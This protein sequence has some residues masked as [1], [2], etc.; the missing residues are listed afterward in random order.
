MALGPS[1][2]LR[3]GLGSTSR[4]DGGGVHV[5]VT[6]RTGPHLA[7]ALFEAAGLDRFAALVLITKRP[8]GFRA[9]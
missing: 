5:V 1:A 2:V 8:Y 4:D 7:P 3:A 9:A 6:S